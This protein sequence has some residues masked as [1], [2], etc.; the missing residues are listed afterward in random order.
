VDGESGEERKLDRIT[1]EEKKVTIEMD[2]EMDGV[3][4][5]IRVVA[6]EKEA[7]TLTGKWLIAGADGT[8]FMSGELSA[9]KE[10]A[11]ALAGDWNATSILP[12][13]SELSSTLV[14]SGENAKL[15]GYF[16]SKDD[17]E[18]K[19]G[20]LTSK[21]KGLR[22][23]FEMDIQGTAM[24]VVIESELEDE[25]KLAGKWIVKGADGSEAASGDWSA[26]RDAAKDY[27]GEWAVSAALPDGGKYTGTLTL[28][29]N[30]DG[31]SGKSKS[32]DG[33]ARELNSVKVDDGNIVFTSDFDANGATGIITVTAKEQEDG[34]LSGSW[35]LAS[36][37]T[38]VAT[39]SWT[40]TKGENKAGVLKG[41]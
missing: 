29:K 22:L 32:T 28:T 35:S 25:N 27:S 9:V 13:G 19:I 8:E 11:V 20:K 33:T 23:D 38:E 34:A 7:N 6:E 41:R 30:E 24:N 37:G 21:D 18:L 26:K 10:M 14:L 4:G 5:L 1:V 40:A 15:E 17:N 2:V 31:Y 3:K 39:D 12:D 16:K 36:D